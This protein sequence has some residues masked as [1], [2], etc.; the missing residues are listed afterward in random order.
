MAFQY[1]SQTDVG[2]QRTTNEDA[3]LA[4]ALDRGY[5]L[6]VADGMGGHARGDIASETALRAFESAVSDAP[7][8]EPAP[9]RLTAAVIAA[10][11][12]IQHAIETNPSY[13]GMGTTLVA[14]YIHGQRVTLINVGDSRA[15]RLLD[16]G[17]EQITI[18]QSLVRDLV[19]EG[20]IDEEEMSTHPQRN[21]VSQALGTRDSDEID[22]DLYQCSLDGTLL[23]CSDGLT[24]ELTDEMIFELVTGTE[25]LETASEALIKQ[26]NENGG[27][28]NISVVL[29]Q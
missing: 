27:S 17:I 16:E 12:A 6:A 15:Y 4:T 29:G 19:T 13:E 22:P 21:V 7:P 11:E 18:D 9:E 10:N 2:R 3:V 23:L 20:V 1:T 25:T 24:E 5:L 28:D 14:A 26:A 8:S